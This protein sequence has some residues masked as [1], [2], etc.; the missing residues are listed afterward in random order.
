MKKKNIIIISIIILII[1]IPTFLIT[2]S[3]IKTITN[4]LK[5][6]GS[7]DISYGILAST[8]KYIDNYIYQNLGDEL[9][10]DIE[11]ICNGSNCEI[12]EKSKSKLTNK[13]YNQTIDI[14]RIIP[15]SGKIKIL[16]NGK[17][18]K[19]ENLEINEL[20]CNNENY[21]IICKNKKEQI[22][23][24][25]NEQQ[26]STIEKKHCDII[27]NR[28]YDYVLSKGDEVSICNEQFNIIYSNS[29]TT[30]MLAKYNLNV[31]NNIQEGQVGIQ[32][33]K[34]IG[35]NE[36]EATKIDDCYPGAV[37]FSGSNYWYNNATNSIN[38]K[39]GNNFPVD[40]Y[41]L[42]YQWKDGNKY[43]IIRYVEQYKNYLIN[44][45]DVKDIN[46]RL[47]TYNEAT[48]YFGCGNHLC[49]TYGINSFITNTSFWMG[50][51]QDVNSVWYTDSDGD[52][53]EDYYTSKFSRGVRPVIEVPTSNIK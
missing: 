5:I 21:N 45:L 53:Y 13:K 46:A 10:K 12:T 8:N 11:F 36:N 48:T 6:K 2:K 9:E 50:T 4:Q 15:K 24:K 25:T 40:I 27:A 33:S 47:L 35:W 41:D 22:E 23:E 49:P 19:L 7:K 39:Y 44:Q 52:F 37:A 31:G 16:K 14:K 1:I 26:E 34:A 18:I 28:E 38:E 29:E 51:A 43:S 42:E 32:N 17:A 30:V 3:Y 20:Y